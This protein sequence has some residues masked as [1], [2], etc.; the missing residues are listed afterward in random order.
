MFCFAAC[1]FESPSAPLLYP[2]Y[3]A[4][5]STRTRKGAW[6]SVITAALS[7]TVSGSLAKRPGVVFRLGWRG[8]TRAQ[9]EFA[10]PSACVFRPL[11]VHGYLV[12]SFDTERR[13]VG[14]RL[15][16]WRPVFMTRQSRHCLLCRPFLSGNFLRQVP[17][18]WVYLPIKRKF[19]TC[20]AI[21]F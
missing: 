17:F 2:L 13:L 16:F 20:H 18:W 3:C 15:E 11:T 19:G 21:L 5:I 10:A 4:A 14:S 1:D 9:P 7:S 8:L 6:W 12:A